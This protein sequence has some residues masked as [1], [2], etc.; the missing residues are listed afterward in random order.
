MKILLILILSGVWG[1]S[2]FADPISLDDYL[3]G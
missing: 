2:A 1:M 3:L